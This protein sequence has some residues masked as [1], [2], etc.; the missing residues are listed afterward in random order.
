VKVLG[1]M[2]FIPVSRIDVLTVNM[3]ALRIMAVKSLAAWAPHHRSRDLRRQLLAACPHCI[4][5][6]D[7]VSLIAPFLEGTFRYLRQ[8]ALP[9]RLKAEASLLESHRCPVTMLT[10]MQARI[11]SARPLPLIDVDGDA[12]AFAYRA[13]VHVAAIDLPGQLVRIVG[14]AAG[15]GG[16]APSFRR[17]R[18]KGSR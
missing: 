8:E 1:S 2:N 15:E 17:L 18:I 10:R 6:L 3:A 4:F 5:P 9:I 11:K 12:S 7:P 13:Y 14:A 16:H